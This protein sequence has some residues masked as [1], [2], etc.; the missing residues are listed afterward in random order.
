[1][2]HEVQEAL[3]NAYALIIWEDHKPAYS[4]IECAHFDFH[5]CYECYGLAFVE[6]NVVLGE[7]AD[8]R[9]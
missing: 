7:R 5:Y 9:V 8:L 3:A 2:G 1:L 6:C 4:V